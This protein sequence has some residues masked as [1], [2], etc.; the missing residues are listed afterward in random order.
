MED[1]KNIKVLNELREY[2]TFYTKL[3]KATV[4]DATMAQKTQSCFCTIKF[5]MLP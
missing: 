3:T 4:Q 5:W 1:G 2:H